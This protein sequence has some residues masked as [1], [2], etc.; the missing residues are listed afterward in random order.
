MFIPSTSTPT[1][2]I[3]MDMIITSD[4]QQATMKSGLKMLVEILPEKAS[5]GKGANQGPLVVMIDDDSSEKRAF[6]EF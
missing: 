4:E 2:G 1:S 5:H 3:P 6:R